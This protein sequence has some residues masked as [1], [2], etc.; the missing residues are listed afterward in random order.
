M[1]RWSRAI[2]L[3][4]LKMDTGEISI[5]EHNGWSIGL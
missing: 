1:N 3:V 2:A 4:L 5:G